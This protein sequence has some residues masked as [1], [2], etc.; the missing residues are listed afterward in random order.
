MSIA[1]DV[2]RNGDYDGDR[3]NCGHPMVGEYFRQ[4]IVYLF[5]T[6]N[7]DG[8][9]FDDTQTITQCLGGWEFLGMI[10]SSLR[11]AASAEGR[12][13]PYCV[14]ENSA[15]QPWDI[16][17]PS[18]GVMD[19][20][21]DI[22]EVY[23]IRDASYDTTNGSD[24]ALSLKVE[25]DKPV[26]WGR[27]FYQATRFGE[28]HDM[29]SGQDPLNIRIA[30]RPPFGQGY[31]MAKAFGALA[32]F[33]NGVPMLFMGQE[34]GETVAF[35]FSNNDQ[36]INPQV[37]DLPPVAATDRTRI[38]AWFRQLMGLRNDPSK[39]LQGDANYQVVATGNRTEAF[40]C[41]AGQQLF[42]IA[43]FGTPNQR[44][45]TSW[46]GLPSGAAY[47][48]IFN[49][50]WPDFQV[51]FEQEWANGGYNVQIYSGQVINLPSIGAVVLERR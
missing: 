41:G 1:P 42:V 2:Y 43:T 20:Q 19:G 24:G 26:Y 35:S 12:A 16:S 11:A 40:V 22:D 10:R 17:N 50:S 29:V 15:T 37:C 6:F 5:R 44:Q 27:P 21:W 45:D 4:A 14:A 8:F 51:E 23:R 32:L 13:W 30:A 33:S 49:S 47:K 34:I 7:L 39:G 48:E 31:Q 9:R 18:W 36:W 38:L 25:M 3:M 46:L 28:S